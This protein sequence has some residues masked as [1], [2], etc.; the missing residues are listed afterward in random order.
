MTSHCPSQI[1]LQL[2]EQVSYVCHSSKQKNE[3]LCEGITVWSTEH[4]GHPHITNQM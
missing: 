1:P 4:V 2:K 3:V